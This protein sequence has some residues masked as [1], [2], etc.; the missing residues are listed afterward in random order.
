MRRLRGEAALEAH[1][2]LLAAVV[3]AAPVGLFALDA[4]GTVLLWNPAAA[5][6]TGLDPEQVLGRN[7]FGAETAI[8][9][10]TAAAAALAELRAGRATGGRFPAV[11]PARRT[12]Y[13]RASPVRTGGPV[14]AVVLLQ[15]V[16]EGRAGDEAFALLEALWESAPVGLAYFDTDLRYR[17]VNGA[18]TDID[19]GSAEQ[20]L[21]RTLE[22]TH[23][24]TGARIAATL[25]AVLSDGEP[26][27]GVPVRGRLWHGTGPEQVWSLDGYPVR[28]AD[29]AVIGVGLLVTD[30]TEAERTRQELIDVAAQRQQLLTRYQSLVEAT[31]AAVWIRSADGSAVEDSPSM[32]AITGQAPEDYLGWG[33]LDAVHPDDRAS[34]RAAWMHAVDTGEPFTHT[35]R[36]RTRRGGYRWYRARAV[37]AVSYT[38]LT[39]PT[40]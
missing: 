40:N 1:E 24:E 18:V 27:R 26:R 22:E 15:D 19:G 5:A 14:A 11:V 32:R 16:A 17:R 30:I 25:T 4:E 8:V 10:T 21:G 38:H 29:G 2:D 36:L 23:G 34:K 12:L 37:A 7:G 31:S 3:E 9:D 13:Y 6:L 39:L 33:F 35:N 28:G 20:R